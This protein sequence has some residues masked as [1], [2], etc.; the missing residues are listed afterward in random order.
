MSEFGEKADSVLELLSKQKAITVE[1]LMQ[2]LFIDD[3]SIINFMHKG[4]LIEI[5]NGKVRLTDFGSE[6][7]SVK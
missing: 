2:N 3:V 6:V 4:E 1:E 7:I 5:K